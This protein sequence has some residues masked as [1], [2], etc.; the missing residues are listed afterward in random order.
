MLRLLCNLI[1]KTKLN[2]IELKLVGK[3]KV[4]WSESNGETY[5]SSERYLDDK[6]VA[7]EGQSLESGE[8][9]FPFRFYLPRD[10]PSSL[11]FEY[12][13]V[14]Y[15]ITCTIIK[16]WKQDNMPIYIVK[17]PVELKN[18]IVK[19]S[20]I[21]NGILDLNLLPWCRNA[22]WKMKE[23]DIGFS[24]WTSGLISAI[25]QTNRFVCFLNN[26]N[27]YA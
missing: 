7:F 23:R 15:K 19:H 8:Y 14:E 17:R 22:N 20:I 10:I 2:R 1:S 5:S 6:M 16:V 4:R 25:L 18:C 26:C 12:G 21:V 24:C 27:R 13:N 9:T 3:G 11:D